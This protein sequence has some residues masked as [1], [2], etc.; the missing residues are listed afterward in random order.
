MFAKRL[1][2]FCSHLASRSLPDKA[3]AVSV[4]DVIRPIIFLLLDD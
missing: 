3:G 4:V 1:K 2:S